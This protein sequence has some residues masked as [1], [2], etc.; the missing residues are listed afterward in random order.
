MSELNKAFTAQSGLKR[1]D[2]QTIV[3]G[4]QV[5]LFLL[6]NKNGLEMCVTNFG[7]IVASLMVPDKNDKLADIVL[8][9]STIEEYLNSPEKYLG[10]AIGRYGNRIKRG[11]FT[12]DGITYKVPSDNPDCSLHGG[13]VGYNNVVWDA[14]QK[15]NQTLELRYV[16]INGEEGF[17]GTL[18]IK[19]VY[20]LTDNNEF[21]ITYEAVTDKATVLNLTHHSFFNLNGEGGEAVTNH[22]VTIQADFFTPCDDKSV[23]TGE[24]LSVSETPMDFRQPH[25]VGERIDNDFQQLVFGVGYDHNYVLKKNYPGELSFAAKAISP[26]TGIEM[27]VYTTEPGVQLYTGNWLNGFEGKNGHKYTKRT[28]ICFETQHFPDSPNNAHF[29][30]TVLRPGEEYT[31]TCIYKFK[32]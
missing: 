18:N 30:S 6:K 32:K 14:D 3:S 19:M 20:C 15:D 29:P 27:E 4:K 23:P 22:E 13:K 1:E 7:G 8:G 25:I 10:A 16:S 31:Q 21:L 28:A 2:F 9:H 17:P 26:L 12:L 24:I 5:D 11:E